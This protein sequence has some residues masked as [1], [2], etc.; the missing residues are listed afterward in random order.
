MKSRIVAFGRVLLALAMGWFA[1][2]AWAVPWTVQFDAPQAREV[3]LAGEMTQW[4]TGKKPL[5][6]D[7]SGRWTL[8]LDVPEGLWLYKLVVD[9]Q[10][11]ADP[12]NPLSDNDGQGGRHSILL[13]GAG[14][15]QVPDGAPRGKVATVDLPSAAW[16]APSRYH[17]YL[18]PGHDAARPAPLLLLLHG[19]G[20]DA[21]QWL[22]TGLV[23][24]YMDTLIA[25]GRIRPFIVAMPTSG[26]VPYT[27][28]SQQFIL[29]ELLPRLRKDHGVT[30]RPEHTAVAG[31]SMGGF[32]A[33]HLGLQAP[34]RFGFV[35]AMSAPFPVDYLAAL[36]QPVNPPFQLQL[37]CGTEDAVL[38]NSQDLAG[39][40]KA[41]GKRFFYSQSP[42]GHDWHYWSGLT[43]R[44]LSQA[45]DFFEGR[46][47]PVNSRELAF[48]KPDLPAPGAERRTAEAWTPERLGEFVGR[49]RGTWKLAEGGASGRFTMEV[50]HAD[51]TRIAGVMNWY[52][53]G[54]S[55]FENLAFEDT[56]QI[57]AGVLGL[58]KVTTGV[59]GRPD[60]GMRFKLE[61]AADGP[62]LTFTTHSSQ[63]VSAVLNEVR[64]VP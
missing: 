45:S 47:L 29:D 15:W 53:P 35:H 12:G 41:G 48:T 46:R 60:P 11:I 13:L 6:R 39:L 54:T 31:M 49:W 59:T 44:M 58:P 27:G 40:L 17:V 20:M 61:R 10:W 37:M 9:G 8:S 64:K 62:V 2:A 38:Q 50:K 16:G 1:S 55:Q 43:P 14:D 21:D 52:V 32:G 28:K 3:F 18:P 34:S 19:R 7:A 30:L 56:P 25:Q 5:A 57:D 26:A 63:P 4:D 23:D 36:P 24:R 33:F 51:A 42:G 22:R